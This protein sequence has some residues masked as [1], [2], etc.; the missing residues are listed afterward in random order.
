MDGHRLSRGLGL[1]SIGLGAAELAVPARVAA[2]V[3]IAPVRGARPVL[4]ALGA[5]EIVSGAGLLAGGPRRALPFWMRVAGD[6]VDVGLLLWAARAPR[7]R[8]ARV[9][10]AVAALAGIAALDIY[11]ARRAAP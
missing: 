5:R 9:I 11:A 8:R 3:G 10:A 1:F 7:T 6:A 4:R 2:L